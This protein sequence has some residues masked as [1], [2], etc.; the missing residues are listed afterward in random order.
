MR[1]ERFAC[2][3]KGFVEITDERPTKAQ[4]MMIKENLH[5][6]FN[7]TAKLTFVFPEPKKEDP[8]TFKPKLKL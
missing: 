3:L 7:G 6:A 2:W 1:Y 4:W 8:D 5:L